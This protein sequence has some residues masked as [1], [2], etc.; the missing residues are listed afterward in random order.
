MPGVAIK[1]II[2]VVYKFP[3]LLPGEGEKEAEK[4]EYLLTTHKLVSFSGL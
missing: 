4:K 3:I 1:K 2:K